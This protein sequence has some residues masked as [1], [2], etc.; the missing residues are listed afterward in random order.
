MPLAAVSR[1]L[2]RSL[3]VHFNLLCHFILTALSHHTG[4]STQLLILCATMH[5][6]NAVRCLTTSHMLVV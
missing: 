4:T 5:Q 2:I 6:R 3:S 1:S